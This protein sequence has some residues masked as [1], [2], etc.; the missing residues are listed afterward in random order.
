MIACS[1]A[2]RTPLATFKIIPSCLTW[3]VFFLSSRGHLL[4]PNILHYLLSIV[5]SYLDLSFLLSF[6]ISFSLSLTQSLNKRIQSMCV[7]VYTHGAPAKGQEPVACHPSS[8]TWERSLC[9]LKTYLKTNARR[10]P[11]TGLS[12]SLC[13]ELLSAGIHY[14]SCHRYTVATVQLPA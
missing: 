5:L 3:G 2:S 1:L 9:S 7:Y 13:P 8:R 10:E 6:E 4:S 11:P 12:P 14:F